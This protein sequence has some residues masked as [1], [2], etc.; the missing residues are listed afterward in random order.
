MIIEIDTMEIYSV[1][2]GFVSSVLLSLNV[3]TSVIHV[4][5]FCVVGA[6]GHLQEGEGDCS[7]A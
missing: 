2:E 3:F 7:T 4:L 1:N 5:W 6:I